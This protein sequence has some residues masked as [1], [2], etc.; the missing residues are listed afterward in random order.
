MWSKVINRWANQVAQCVDFSRHTPRSG[1]VGL[2]GHSM[3]KVWGHRQALSKV[4]RLWH[5]PISSAR[6]LVSPALV[7][8]L[9][10]H[11]ES[12]TTEAT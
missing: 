9:W 2:C 1:M 8:C 3:R 12:D 6:G 11:T 7:C 4:T 10:D 5:A